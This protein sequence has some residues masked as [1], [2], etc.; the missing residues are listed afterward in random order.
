MH[1]RRTRRAPP[2]AAGPP[3]VRRRRPASAGT[4]AVPS[5]GPSPTDAR[6]AAARCG[7]PCPAARPVAAASS[8]RPRA[9]SDQR[10]DALRN[11]VRAARF[12]HAPHLL[13]CAVAPAASPHE[14]REDQPGVE[15]DLV[16][17]VLLAVAGEEQSLGRVA[18]NLALVALELRRLE[19]V[20]N[21]EYAAI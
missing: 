21:G 6:S 13:S 14:A 16:A 9:G 17:L 18:Q 12:E 3:Q 5:S 8:R 15:Q 19:L 7:A 1:C 4:R 20:Q 11:T 10:G 2:P